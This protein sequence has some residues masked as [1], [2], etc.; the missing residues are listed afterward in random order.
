MNNNE[1]DLDIFKTSMLNFSIF[2]LRN[3]ILH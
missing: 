1:L 3:K 2:L